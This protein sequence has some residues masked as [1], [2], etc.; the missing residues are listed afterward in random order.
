M[1][2]QVEL[3][4][5]WGRRRAAYDRVDLLEVVQGRV[6]EQALIR[7]LLPV[8]A[9]EVGPAWRIRVSVGNAPPVE[10]VITRV[11][12][13]WSDVRKLVL[14]RYV[15]YLELLEFEAASPENAGNAPVSRA[16]TN[17]SVSAMV[18]DVINSARGPIHY[19]VDHTAYPDGAQREYAK[20]SERK[21]DE[22]ELEVGGIAVGDWVGGARIDASGASAKDG[23]TIQG[24]VVDGEAW[25]EIR[26]MMIDAE[27][28]ARNSHAISRH[29]EV[30]GW[31]SARYLRS[32]YKLRADAATARLQALI[33]TKGID[34]IELNPHKD[35]TG[36]YDD[37]VD[38]YDRYLGLIYG[39]GEC[40]NA[41]LVE[42]GLADVY[43]YDGGRYHV[44][45][46]ALKDF[47]SY[48][49]AH[50]NSIE[51]AEETLTQF[52]ATGGV[53]EVLTA[54]AYVAGGY[55]FC[56]D[57][58][59]G[60]MFRKPVLPDHALFFDPLLYGVELGAST[61]DL[62]N[63]LFV[64]GN[65][66]SGAVAMGF[67]RGESITAYGF[68]SR[69]LTY[70]SLTREDDAEKLADGVL[71]DLAYPEP[72]GEV[73]CFG[74]HDRVR[75]GD[76]L[77]LRGAPLQRRTEELPAEWDG[78]FTGKIVAG[79]RSVRHRMYG[80]TVETSLQL[81]SPLRS[82]SAPLSYI[83]RSQE[84]ASS[85]FAFRFDDIR[86][87]LDMGFHLD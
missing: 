70:F 49:G 1:R 46:M 60:V 69:R 14:D 56:V 3:L 81:G 68:A 72:S 9:P 15:N 78:R 10:A 21:T 42:E 28:S 71:A 48:V 55:T 58:D 79:V 35:A 18:R 51:S 77:E 66:L 63:Y 22:N 50:S 87:G 6:D 76:V 86:V 39:G 23:D 47:Y 75:V 19:W 34:Y 25:P 32:G 37:R 44:P 30:A 62:G 29:P 45:E 27:E 17:Q 65:P 16:Y 54:L 59:L 31:D 7:G 4:D 2:Y 52:D 61:V 24:L 73:I 12:P 67:S 8:D 26:L 5:P 74:G 80:R 13:V 33:D 11:G 64:E 84:S 43:L 57:G 38:A 53:L 83:V 41:A 36:A 20:F 82:V 85:L 40:F